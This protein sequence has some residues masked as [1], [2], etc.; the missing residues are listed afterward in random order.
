MPEKHPVLLVVEDDTGL[1]LLIENA[2]LTA[3]FD[4]RLA[5]TGKE[6]LNK[7]RSGTKPDFILMD[8]SLP[9]MT[10]M[11]LMDVMEQEDMV[12]PFI[13]STG[14]GDERIAVEMMKRGAFDYLVKDAHFF[15][16]LPTIIARTWQEIQTRRNLAESEKRFKTL[17]DTM[18]EGVVYIN[19]EGDFVDVNP[20]ASRIFGFPAEEMLKLNIKETPWH[21][22]DENGVRF[23]SGKGP[24]SRVIET[25]EPVRNIVVGIYNPSEGVQRWAMENITPLFHPGETQPYLIYAT[26]TDITELRKAQA[27]VV[28]LNQTLEK[29]VRERTAQLESVIH[30]LESFSYTVSHDLRAPL[31]AVTVFSQA[32]MED[33]AEKLDVPGQNYLQRIMNNT[34]RL[35]ELLDDVL[36]LS[37][38]SRSDLHMEPVN[39]SE[40]AAHVA[41]ELNDIS[42][43]RKIEWLITPGIVVEGDPWL[44]RLMIHNLVENAWKFTS[45]HPTA[46]IEFDQ[47]TDEHGSRV[48]FIRDDGAGF[49][50]T[51]AD[52]LFGMFQRLHP[53][54]EF[55][56]SGIGLATIQRIIHRHGGRIWAEGAVEKGATFYFTLG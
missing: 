46:R 32:L 45:R 56:G 44:L 31:R 25:G 5:Q 50:M 10:A 54:N 18:A 48:I 40:I 16:Y 8:Y 23:P 36:K 11:D 47:M 29:K 12:V 35:G 26:L 17:F 19:P 34:H 4:C 21:F 42:G 14:Q 27:E 38:L 49:D 33:Y 2:I 20:A 41:D 6:A 28:A 52:K 3:G 51:Y 22:M 9:D 15:D 7:L 55:D 53:G 24:G 13:V 30:E 39:L 43:D 1:A 37:Y